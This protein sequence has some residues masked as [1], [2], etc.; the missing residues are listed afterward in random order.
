MNPIILSVL[1][2][3]GGVVKEIKDI[4]GAIASLIKGDKA[5]AAADA[6]AALDDLAALIGAGIINIPGLAS[7]DVVAAL[8]G[9]KAVL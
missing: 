1:L 8:N 6:Q 2:H 3:I 9:L 7:A 4:E 5:T